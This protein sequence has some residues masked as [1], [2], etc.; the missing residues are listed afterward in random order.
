MMYVIL[1]DCDQTEC[2]R[3]RLVDV[4]QHIKIF[5]A[6]EVKLKGKAM[7]L[8]PNSLFDSSWIIGICRLLMKFFPIH[9][10]SFAN[11]L[12]SDEFNDAA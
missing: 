8:F 3:H 9:N 5:C 7:A 4:F 1:A 11:F 2:A 12:R 10:L 6:K